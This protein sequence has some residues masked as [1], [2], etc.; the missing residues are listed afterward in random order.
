MIPTEK[1]K[2]TKLPYVFGK[3]CLFMKHMTTGGKIQRNFNGDREGKNNKQ[4]EIQ[5]EEKV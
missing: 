2:N 4:M 5:V 3:I 1:V